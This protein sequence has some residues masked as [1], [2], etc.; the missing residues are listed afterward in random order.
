MKKK[1]IL[2]GYNYILHYR[3]P[4][5]NQLSKKYD[6][7]VLHSGKSINVENDLFSELIFPTNKIGPFFV[8]RGLIGTIEKNKYDYIILLFDPRWVNTLYSILKFRK[9]HK[10][11]LWG[12]WFT[13][14][15]LINKLRIL[16]SKGVFSNIYYNHLT[17]LDFQDKGIKNTY[18]ANNTFDVGFRTKCFNYP[19]K[20]Y[21]L[22]VGSLDL[23]KQNDILIMSFKKILNKIPKNINLVFV[24]SGKESENLKKLSSKLKLNDRIK[25]NG[26]IE[27]PDKLKIYYNRAIVS[28][29]FGQAGLTVLQSLGYGVPFLTKINS[30]SG[31]EKFNIKNNYNGIL[32]EDN[33]DSLSDNLKKMCLNL[34]FSRK[35]GEN[36]FNYYSKYCTIENMTQG[37]LD[38][39]EKTNKT[40]IDNS[41]K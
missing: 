11:I 23:R 41:L 16:F 13:K 14:N 40:I 9:T 15:Y 2:I 20:D 8:Q 37:F 21:I 33:I 10:L 25:F 4:L 31:G 6:V 27:N 19:K 29:S 12:G 32:C 35:L 24:G 7:T 5:F 17:R 39:I 30:I 34:D 28:V 36:A 18:V 22:F 26:R 1:K 3:K 38:A